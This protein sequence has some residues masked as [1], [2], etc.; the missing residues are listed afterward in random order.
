M[1]VCARPLS[2]VTGN[3]AHDAIVVRDVKLD[4]RAIVPGDVFFALTQSEHVAQQHVRDAVKAGA[5]AVVTAHAAQWANEVTSVP[6][7]CMPEITQPGRL[8]QLADRFYDQPSAR[9]RVVGI[10]GTNGKTTCSQWIAEAWSALRAPAAAMGTLGH[11][12]FVAGERDV[13][14]AGV[15]GLTT[16][17]VLSNHR[18]L[19]S[20]CDAGAEAVAMEV[21]SHALDQGRVDA[22][23]F[24][25]AIFTNL[26]QDHLDYHGDMATYAAAKHRLFDIQGLQWAIINVDD[27]FGRTLAGELRQRSGGCKVIGYS[28]HD[29]EAADI[30]VERSEV[31]GQCTVATVRTPWGKGVLQSKYPGG[32]NLLNVLA[33]VA[34]LC[35]HGMALSSVLDV[36]GRLHPVPGRTQIVSAEHDDVL[37]IV[38]YAHTP[39]ALQKI[40]SAARERCSGQLWCVFGCGG[41][42]DRGKRPQMGAIAT[43]MAERCVVTSDNPRSEAPE[44]IIADIV[45]GCGQ[46]DV[47]VE[48]DREKA[49]HLAIAAAVAGD[50]VVL[51]GK[52]HETYQETQ[53]QRL[54]F[55]DVVVAQAAL[56]ARRA[57]AGRSCA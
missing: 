31:M 23:R 18:L 21:S 54:P 26:T 22:I 38:D 19:A 44:A 13:A 45:T 4:S 42:R 37:V 16:A 27:A 52:G 9:L 33:V 6:V 15:T 47:T 48:Q 39:D 12:V 49:I 36:V 8:G 10:T 35:S 50:V 41:D 3:A 7:L 29:D 43:E 51:A 30:G 1:N 32:F 46:Q 34:T 17:D 28:L 11:S 56:A 55:S 2:K 20:L 24:D 53:G 57:H 25:T 14:A 5:A 40:L